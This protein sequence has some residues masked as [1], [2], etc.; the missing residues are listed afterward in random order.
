MKRHVSLAALFAAA[1]VI[2]ATAQADTDQELI[3]AYEHAAM[4]SEANSVAQIHQHLHHVL[5]CLVGPAGDGYDAG[6]MNPCKGE[7]NGAIPDASGPAQKAMLEQA[8]AKA[9]AGLEA[10]DFASA[11]KAATD[12]ETDIS[13]SAPDVVHSGQ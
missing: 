11:V 2:A 13:A 1:S 10:T 5:N 7:G 9:R 6:Q 8:A 3:H 12:V 4:A